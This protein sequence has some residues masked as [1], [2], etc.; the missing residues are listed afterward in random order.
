[1][2]FQDIKKITRAKYRVDVPWDYLPKWIEDHKN[3]IGIELEPDFQRAHV[4]TDE[5]RI[6]YVEFQLR[7]G[8]SGK[9]IYWN[10]PGWMK[11]GKNQKFGPL[12]L[13]DGL[14]RITSALKFLNN[15]IPVFGAFRKNYEDKLS[16]FD[17]TFIFNVNDLEDRKDVLQWYIDLNDG[18]V[19]HTT[20]EIEKVKK[21]LE[22][23]SK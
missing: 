20:E 6:K 11:V 1:M 8:N 16:L 12:Q 4:W 21:M 15:E 5:K 19:I 13:V 23:E 10:C 2:K 9:E 17:V 18:G 7:G 3:D 14:Q 22:E